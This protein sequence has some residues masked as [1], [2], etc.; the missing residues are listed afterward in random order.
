MADKSPKTKHTISAK[1][2]S[3]TS[4][5][6]VA[7]LGIITTLVSYYVTNDVRINAEEN[8]LTINSRSA[9]DIENRLESIHSNV[10]LLLDMIDASGSEGN[11]SRQATA[12]FFE[13][14]PSI[15]AVIISDSK[16]LINT[17]FFISHELE[18]SVL[19]SF[20]LNE[21]DAI[22]RGKKGEI[23]AVNASPYFDYPMIG[24]IYPYDDGVK[25]SSLIILF[26]KQVDL[27]S[28]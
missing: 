10:Y 8:N 15:A 20:V 28:T 2:I 4:L 24:L 14:N 23:I 26:L 3:I 7:A 5:I 21:S 6:V 22:Q 9:A 25:Q 17:S 27:E 16:T 12:F 13:R 11:L 19:E 18:N 1:L